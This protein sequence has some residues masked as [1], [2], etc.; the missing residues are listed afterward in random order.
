MLLAR[1]HN[2]ADKFCAVCERRGCLFI[3]LPDANGKTKTYC[4]AC[5]KTLVTKR[6]NLAA[7]DKL[8]REQI[9]RGEA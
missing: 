3:S 4:G 5:A 2:L 7:Q 9:R 8:M 1:A 6:S